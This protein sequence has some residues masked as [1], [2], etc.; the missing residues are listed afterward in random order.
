MAARRGTRLGRAAKEKR[1][2]GL[3]GIN[4]PKCR[5]PLFLFSVFLSRF[6]F[7]TSNFDYDLNMK[8]KCTRKIK[9]QHAMQ[10]L[11][12]SIVILLIK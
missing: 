5:F 7:Q 9:I 4:R 12:L 2:S 3:S 1:L 8:F 11:F 10:V 6:K